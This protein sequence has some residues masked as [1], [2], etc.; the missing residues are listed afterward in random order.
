MIEAPPLALDLSAEEVGMRC[1]WN[2][3]T[4]PSTLWLLQYGPIEKYTT[5]EELTAQVFATREIAIAHFRAEV[6]NSYEFDLEYMDED[7]D[8]AAEAKAGIEASIKKLEAEGVLTPD[9]TYD[10]Q[11][12][13]LREVPLWTAAPL[14]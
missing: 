10:G 4:V 14:I 11:G 3:G 12:V 7:S 8:E 13:C 6:M 9:D 1:R 5:A 2:G